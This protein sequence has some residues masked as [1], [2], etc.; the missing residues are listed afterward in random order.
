MQCLQLGSLSLAHWIGLNCPYQDIQDI[1]GHHPVRQLSPTEGQ[2]QL[3]TDWWL[4][5]LTLIRK[6]QVNLFNQVNKFTEDLPLIQTESG[7]QA[8][9]Y[10]PYSFSKGASPAVICNMPSVG[11]AG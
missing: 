8:E 5:M 4:L 3:E 6:S 2:S 9:T 1:V 10:C 11:V 7:S